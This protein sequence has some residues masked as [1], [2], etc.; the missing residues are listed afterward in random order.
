MSAFFSINFMHLK[1]FI[2]IFLKR[3]GSVDFKKFESQ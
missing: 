2:V 3:K 1:Y